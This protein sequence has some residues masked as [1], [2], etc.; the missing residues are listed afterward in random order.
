MLRAAL[1]IQ[2]DHARSPQSAGFGPW[3]GWAAT[4]E[5]L[6]QSLRAAVKARP[7]YGNARYNLARA[8][9]TG[10]EV[11]VNA[12]ENFEIVEKQFPSDASVRHELADLYLRQQK[13][14]EAVEQFDE[15]LAIDPTDAAARS[16]REV[17]LRQA[18]TKTMQAGE[19]RWV[20]PH[21]LLFRHSL[22]KRSDGKNLEA[23]SRP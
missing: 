16:S 10:G 22:S 9:R 2:P 7:D 11:G 21:K 23:F 5:A 20:E 17:A 12:V 4:R 13:F 14:S 1:R 3:L 15:A 19:I 6:E 8:P 18:P